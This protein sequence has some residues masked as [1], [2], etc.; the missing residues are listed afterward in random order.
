MRNAQV[1]E[2]YDATSLSIDLLKYWSTFRQVE[3]HV[4]HLQIVFL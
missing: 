2:Y 1:I 4:S 3:L